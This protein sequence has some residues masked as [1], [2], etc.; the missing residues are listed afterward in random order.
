M[1]FVDLMS[2]RKFVLV[3]SL[4]SNNLELAKAALE[5]GADAV[6]VH[7][8]VWHRASGHTF[9]TYEENKAF[10]KD[11]I[12]LC[13][14]VPVGLVPGTSE[15]F[16][17]E[18]EL[19][20]LEEMGLDFISAYSQNLPSFVMDSRKITSAVAI[21]SDYTE[22][23]LDA[24]KD[25]DI[26]ILEC[27]VVRGEAYGQN[28]TCAD[29]LCYSSIA[30]RT[31]KPCMIPTQKKIRPGDVKH[32]YRAGCRALMIGAV[33][34]GQEPDPEVFQETVQAFREAVDAL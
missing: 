8:N 32:L 4:P 5:G 26:E 30:K 13:S 17:T 15:A 28:L 9:G 34:T 23:T 25:S 11:L 31:G 6:K 18:S 24:V 33:V 19:R 10:L 1:R 12:R 27:S 14:D 21:G 3:V 2:D 29:L 22:S 16:I 20:E 7:C